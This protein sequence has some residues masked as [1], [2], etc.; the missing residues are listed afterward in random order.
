MKTEAVEE[1]DGVR[2]SLVKIIDST[3]NSTTRTGT[4]SS[5]IRIDPTGGTSQ[6]IS[7]TITDGGSGKTLKSASF[8]LSA[9][10]TVVAAVS[11][12]RIKVFAIKLVVSAALSVNFRDGASTAIEGAQ[13]LAI[14]GGIQEAV[15]P[16]SFLFG[17]SAGNSLDLVITGIGAAAGRISYFDDDAA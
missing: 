16:P 11:S 4:S 17:T 12:K 10:G 15:T 6:P 3:G 5:P 14:N 13:A 9:T 7:G 1:I 8:S 2:Y